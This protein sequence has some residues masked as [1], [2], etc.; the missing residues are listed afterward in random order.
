[1]IS[2]NNEG[3]RRA[4][5]GDLE[6]AAKLLADAAQQLPNNTQIVLNAA[7][8]LLALIRRDGPDEARMTQTATL[9]SQARRRDAGHPKLLKLT[10]VAREAAR[11]HRVNMQ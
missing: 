5:K 6:G 10:T 8:A 2:L 9:L 11:K 4:Q 1:V 7:H 3:V